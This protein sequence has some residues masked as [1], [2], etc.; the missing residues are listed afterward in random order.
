MDSR[1]RYLIVCGLLAPLLAAGCNSPYHADRGALFGGLLG[2][3]TGAIVGDALGNAGAGAAIGA[4]V[5]ALSGAAIGD[6]MDQIEARNRAQIAAQLG[7]EVRAGSVSIE[8][9]VMMSQAGVD[10]QLI[11]N[12]VRA[13]GVTRVPGPHELVSL[14]Q[15]GVSSA[16]VRAMQEPPPAPRRETVVIAQP[17]PRPVIV[18]EYHYGYGAPYY[19]YPPPYRYRRPVHHDGPRVGWGLSFH[20]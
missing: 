6:S 20:N 8:D 12:H 9:V 1:I 14:T 16:V 11:I 17:A 2:A 7:R 13:N 4:G 19:H 5:G 10:D 18:E 3:G 15:Q